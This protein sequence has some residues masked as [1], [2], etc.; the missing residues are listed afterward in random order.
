MALLLEPKAATTIPLELEGITPDRVRKLDIPQ[1][2]GME[3]FEGNNK[4]HL[5]DFFD[6]SGDPSDLHMRLQGDFSGVHW[7]GTKMS[8]GQITVEGSIGRHLGSEMTGG[9]IDV[10]GDASD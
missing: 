4:A 6:V 9:R 2:L 10:S 1:I 8:E 7:V 3:I 5:G